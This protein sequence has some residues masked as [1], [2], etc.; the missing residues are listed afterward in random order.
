[1]VKRILT[2]IVSIALLM[3]V[4]LLSHTALLPFALATLTLFALFEI[5]RCMKVT[6]N[7]P[8]TIPLYAAGGLLPFVVRYL[9]KTSKISLGET[10]LLLAI[11]LLLYLLALPVLTKNKTTCTDAGPAFLFA[12][13][14][15]LG[16]SGVVYLRDLDNP[17]IYLLIL[18]GAWSTDI[19]AYLFGISLGRHKLIPEISPKK[20]IEGSIGGGLA[21]AAAFVL[22]SY[23][24]GITYIGWGYIIAGGIL[25]SLFAQTGDLAMSAVKRRYDIK[26]C[27]GVFPGHGGVLDRFDSVLSVSSVMTILF[28]LINILR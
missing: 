22:T 10:A 26:D 9:P 19:F 3:P 4:L 18:V 14:I 25:V 16:F 12:L 1:M 20:T 7:L 8:L 2:T 5:F 11:L 28:A 24:I 6:K 15:T 13:Y 17:H 21:G 27:G 23:L